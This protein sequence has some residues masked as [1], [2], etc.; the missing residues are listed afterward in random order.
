MA[1][2]W[3]PDEYLQR[4]YASLQA[5]RERQR[6]EE[7]V[8]PPETRQA[9]R[10]AW[11]KAALGPWPGEPGAEEKP[12]LAPEVL[13]LEETGELVRERIAYTT[14]EGLRV[15][16]YVLIPK[17]PHG[18]GP[19]P[20]VLALHGHGSGS[21]QIAGLR[22]D[23]SPA[24]ESGAGEGTGPFALELCRR[25]F[26]VLA[27]EIAG[28][29]D[30]RLAWDG[31]QNPDAPNSC[32]PLAAALLLAGRTLAGLRTYEAIRAV[33]VLAAREEAD[34]GRIGCVGFSG[35]GMIASLTAAFDERIRA[36]VLC[37]YGGT[38]RDSILARRHC[39][40]NYVPGILPDAELPELL[41]LIAPRALYLEAG[42]RDHLFPEAA[43][44]RAH[45][46]LVS[47]YEELGAPT[48]PGFDLFDGGHEVS[49]RQSFG[50]LAAQLAAEP[51]AASPDGTEAGAA[52]EEVG[53]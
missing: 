29:G 26:M 9:R 53:A 10:R 52:A 37:G 30:R 32:F 48:V 46:Y 11:L 31:E 22:A 28:F 42:Q 7:A 23:G 13:E 21:R 25:G 33:D 50:W 2:M 5:G 17:R 15:P 43:V 16:A 4:L 14:A 36:T 24:E 47:L 20:A 18:A 3:Q 49:G 38:Y 39:L 45:R 6:A 40:D 34:A 51:P 19:L 41:G 1:V 12:P 8:V 44:R 35:G 27:P